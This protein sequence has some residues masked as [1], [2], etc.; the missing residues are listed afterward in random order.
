LKHR[1]PKD[2]DCI[3]IDGP[4]GMIGR[5]GFYNNIHLFRKDI[6][7]I[8]DDVNRSVEYTLLC[9]VA[10]FLGRPFTVFKDEVG[11]EFGVIL[12]IIN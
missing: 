1:L 10:D 7:Y 4:L 6:P 8:F 5:Y 9:D 11:K 2:Y 3:L 12:P